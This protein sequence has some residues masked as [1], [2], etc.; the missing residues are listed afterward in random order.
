MM[1]KFLKVF[2]LTTT[3]FSNIYILYSHTALYNIYK[4]TKYFAKYRDNP[5]MKTIVEAT[6][7]KFKKYFTK[8]PLLYCFGIVLDPQ[9]KTNRL[10]NILRL[11]SRN[12]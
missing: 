2:Y 11:M 10:Y 5:Q 9:L 4:V 6:E 12:V 7:I 1:I 3:A 8:L